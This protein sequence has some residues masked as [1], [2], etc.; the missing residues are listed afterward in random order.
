M[1]RRPLSKKCDSV[2]CG[3]MPEIELDRE[4]EQCWWYATSVDDLGIMPGIVPSLDREEHGCTL[5]EAMHREVYLILVISYFA[6][7]WMCTV[8]LT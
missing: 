1:L 3:I 8:I 7:C 5:L 2:D 4:I 6:F